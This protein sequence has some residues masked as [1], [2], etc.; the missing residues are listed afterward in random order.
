MSGTRVQSRAVTSAHKRNPF[1]GLQISVAAMFL[2]MLGGDEKNLWDAC[3]RQH[4]AV[5]KRATRDDDRDAPDHRRGSCVSIEASVMERLRRRLWKF[6]R[7]GFKPKRHAG[8]SAMNL[9]KPASSGVKIEVEL[10]AYS[11]FQAEARLKPTSRASDS[12]GCRKRRNF[13]R[14]CISRGSRKE[15]LVSV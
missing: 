10:L 11:T 13:A 4:D 12:E 6:E 15:L 3:S 8:V 7:N 1:W 14:Q 2:Q 5:A 9:T